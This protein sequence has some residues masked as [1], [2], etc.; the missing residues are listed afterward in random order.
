M[1]NKRN[2]NS[3]NAIKN[4][5]HVVKAIALI[6]CFV[7]FITSVDITAMAFT[8]DEDPDTNIVEVTQ[9]NDVEAESQTEVTVEGTEET[10][11]TLEESTTVEETEETLEESTAVEETEETPVKSISEKNKGKLKLASKNDTNRIIKINGVG[12]EVAKVVETGAPFTNV[13]GAIDAATDGQTVRLVKDTNESVTVSGKNIR[14]DLNGYILKGTDSARVISI[15]NGATLSIEDS[16]A[17]SVHYFVY[18]DNSAWTLSENASGA[19]DIA[20]F[21]RK[22]ANSGI[23]IVKVTGGCLL[24]GYSPSG[25]SV[26]IDGKN[27][28]ASFSMNGGNIVGS[29]G[30][31]GSAVYVDGTGTGGNASFSMN[32]NSKIVGCKADGNGCVYV[33]GTGGNANFS[34]NGNSAII[35]CT[36]KESGAGIFNYNA[37]SSMNN[38]SKIVEN[39]SLMAGRYGGGVYTN[40]S[41]S[42]A[43]NTVIANCQAEKGGGVWVDCGNFNMAGSSTI[44]GCTAT[45]DGGGICACNATEFNMS[46]NSKVTDCTAGNGGGGVY[47]YHCPFI[48]SG[49]SSIS[50]NTAKVNFTTP[51]SGGG[52]C[53]EGGTF[54][55]TGGTISGNTSTQD[56]GGLNIY[57]NN[58]GITLGGTAKITGN[59]KGDANNNLYLPAGKTVNIDTSTVETGMTVGVTTATAPTASTPVA[60]TGDNGADY[61]SYFTSDNSAYFVKNDSNV[62]KLAKKAKAQHTV[63][64]PKARNPIYNGNEQVL[65]SPGSCSTGTIKYSLNG[66]TYYESVNSIKQA[67]VGTYTVYYKVDG[68]DSYEAY[69]PKTITAK[70][71]KQTK[72]TPQPTP[73]SSEP[74]SQ[75]SSESSD[76][77]SQSDSQS[78]IPVV[79]YAETGKTI[80]NY[81]ENN[82][83]GSKMPLPYISTDVKK[84]GWKTIDEALD[85]HKAKFKKKAIGTLSI[86]MNGNTTVDTKLIINAHSKKIPLAFLLDDDVTIGIPVAN[87]VLS[88]QAKAEK[89]TYFNISAMTTAEAV[90]IKKAH[91]GLLPSDI[92]AIGGN[93]NTPVVLILCSNDKLSTKKSH[94]ITISFNAAKAGFKKGAKVYLYSGTSKNGVV[95][96]KSGKVDKNG[97]V[98]FSVPMVNNYWTIGSVG[99]RKM[100]H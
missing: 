38:N 93:E 73:E 36:T 19:V 25:G 16:N 35:G 32:G 37:V 98:T 58:D 3:W 51:I 56:G 43:D 15:S 83:T 40:K 46:A 72:P 5:G 97:L 99:P 45:I 100:A 29:R 80:K 7:L 13:Q 20:D 75:S 94:L 31:H 55:M 67:E 71:V 6:M 27:G 2:V 41:F 53:I 23:T 39:V 57:K 28:S 30:H 33:N 81:V 18:S 79:Q 91:P 90:S 4:K 86:K 34:M 63:V 9:L 48:M 50:N 49:N 59:K 1:K 82:P 77:D 89:A 52:V 61:S 84:V 69:G 8:G 64:A 26:N 14:L 95:M 76:S 60:I 44:K 68:D 24:G 10:E 96:Y 12:E 66:T 78:T 17:T 87:S 47:S 74:E 88:N 92:A 21:G 62:L 42:M 85:A 11:E 54:K 65:I 70:I 22:T